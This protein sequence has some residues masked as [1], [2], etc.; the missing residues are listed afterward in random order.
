MNGPA[1]VASKGLSSSQALIFE[2]S[3][4]PLSSS[5][6]PP[7]PLPLA[8]RPGVFDGCIS[9][10]ALQWLCNA[11]KR[12]HVPQRRL[13][14]FFMVPPALSPAPPTGLTHS[15][16]MGGALA[17]NDGAAG[18]TL[19]SQYVTAKDWWRQCGL[20]VLSLWIGICTIE[21]RGGG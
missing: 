5:A 16:M 6:N 14:C 1:F 2:P 4:N 13:K 8:R 20:W 17:G 12:D 18:L 9:I 19:V 11:D 21:V 7:P 10:S 3:S 15:V